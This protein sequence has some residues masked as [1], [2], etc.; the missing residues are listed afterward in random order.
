MIDVV[1][2][3]IECW[4]PSPSLLVPQITRADTDNSIT[5]LRFIG[6]FAGA[7]GGAVDFQSSAGSSAAFQNVTFAD[8]IAGMCFSAWQC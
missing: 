1:L 3:H 6:N 5:I 7:T 4:L 8:N 2:K